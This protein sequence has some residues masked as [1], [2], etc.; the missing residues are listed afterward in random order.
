VELA[1]AVAHEMNQPLTVIISGAEL[2]A[3]PGRSVEEVR[4]V[5]SRMAEASER[6]ADIVVKL[7]KATCYRNKPYVGKVRIV[8]LD[9]AG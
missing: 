5:A 8:D 3:H 7:Q 4:E 1:G 6:M 2:M 9:R